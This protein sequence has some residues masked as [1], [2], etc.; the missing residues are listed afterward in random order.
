MFH[1]KSQSFQGDAQRIMVERHIQDS[2]MTSEV[3]QSLL[4][5]NEI[6]TKFNGAFRMKPNI[7][8]CLHLGEVGYIYMQYNLSLARMI[9]FLDNVYTHISCN[10]VKSTSASVVVS[11]IDKIIFWVSAQ[12]EEHLC[13]H[14]I[15]CWWLACCL[16]YISHHR[17]QAEI[18]IT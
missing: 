14:P 1:L 16:L 10:L 17:F 9:I 7:T 18:L 11:M 13:R 5:E 12:G 2:A 15:P 8:D 3:S 6:I 4:N